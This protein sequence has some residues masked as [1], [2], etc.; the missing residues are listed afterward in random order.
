MSARY[1]GITAS[2]VIIDYSST[3][4]AYFYPLHLSNPDSEMNMPRLLSAKS[5]DL[6]IVNSGLEEVLSHKSTSSIV[7]QG[8]VDMIVTTYN[9]RLPYL[10]KMARKTDFISDLN[11]LLNVFINYKAT[12]ADSA[13]E[14][15]SKHYL[16][17]ASSSHESRYSDIFC[18]GGR[19]ALYF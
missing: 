5:S 17:A 11:I 1:Q 12:S 13:I 14:Q 15:Y 4:S 9:I 18:T 3:I 7:W 10:A 6:A 16:R 2:R 8:I 19:N